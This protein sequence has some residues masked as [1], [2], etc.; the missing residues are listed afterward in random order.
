MSNFFIPGPWRIG[1]SDGSGP[2]TIVTKKVKS[3]GLPD[4]I[5]RI[6]W[7]CGCCEDGSPLTIEDKATARLI[8][9]APDY[10]EHAYN[11]AMLIYQSKLY[12]SNPKVQLEVDNVFAIYAKVKGR[13]S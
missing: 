6:R 4:A 1:Y 11:L 8:V 7:G 3:T 10:H 12:Q 9:A 13:K 2:D 5:A